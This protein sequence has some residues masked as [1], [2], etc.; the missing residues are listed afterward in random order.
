MKKEYENI[1]IGKCIINSLKQL[2]VA[3]LYQFFFVVLVKKLP[4][5]YVLSEEYISKGFLYKFCYYMVSITFLVRS[6]YYSGFKMSEAAV[7]ICG[8]GYNRIQKINNLTEKK[9][10]NINNSSSSSSNNLTSSNQTSNKES[11]N[12]NSDKED[13]INSRANSTDNN[14]N[15]NNLEENQVYEE[16]F[17]RLCNVNLL[18]FE[19]DINP[20]N[21]II[22]WNCTV[23]KWLKYQVFLRLINMENK[24]FKNKSF[25][26]MITFMLSAIWHGFYPVFY[27]FFPQFYLI[28]QACKV[29]EEKLNLFTKLKKTKLIY[30]IAI[31]LIWM[32]IINYL[33]MGFALLTID[34][35][36]NF[37]KQFYF[38]PNVII[39]IFYLYVVI[40]IGRKKQNMKLKDS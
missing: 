4:P 23:H 25:A 14:H 37:Y 20:L 29:L 9:D 26:S 5:H 11:I 7:I 18:D 31:N 38:I 39:I 13:T 3:F 22:S 10:I 40:F 2:L 17:N 16:T 28:E 36:L 15:V 1:P 12:N 24:L 6:K 33:G 8:L 21:K 34:N 30:K 35:I 27:V 32:G 19:L